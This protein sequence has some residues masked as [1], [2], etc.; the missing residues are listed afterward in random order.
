MMKKLVFLLAIVSLSFAAA[1][2]QVMAVLAAFSALIVLIILYLI[3]YAVNSREMRMMA[4]S[5]MFQVFITMM[6][7]VVFVSFDGYPNV[8]ALLSRYNSSALS[9][10]TL[11]MFTDNRLDIFSGSINQN[12]F[13]DSTTADLC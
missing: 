12:P 10:E 5:E 2:W 4:R 8:S 1:D 3:S 11:C 7:I 13:A 6:L 9:T